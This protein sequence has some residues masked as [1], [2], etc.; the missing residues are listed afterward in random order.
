MRT[1]FQ[2]NCENDRGP[3]EMRAIRSSCYCRVC[4]GYRTRAAGDIMQRN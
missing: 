2:T 4:G 3:R 1:V